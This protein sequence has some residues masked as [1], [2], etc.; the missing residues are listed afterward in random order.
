MIIINGQRGRASPGLRAPLV[1]Y[2]LQKKKNVYIVRENVRTFLTLS[3]PTEVGVSFQVST[4]FRFSAAQGNECLKRG[5]M[6]SQLVHA[7]SQPVEELLAEST[8]FQ[9]SSV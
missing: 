7:I 4:S 9:L 6:F 1:T 2:T 3:L 8:S 5:S